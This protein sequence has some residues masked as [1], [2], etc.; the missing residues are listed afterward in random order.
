M[1][2]CVTTAAQLRALKR[3]Q[4]CLAGAVRARR[5]K[6]QYYAKSATWMAC[7]SAAVWFRGSAC[8]A[9]SAE[10][11]VLARLGADLW[12]PMIA[13]D[14]LQPLS[15]NYRRRRYTTIPRTEA[16]TMGC[17]TLART[18]VVYLF[19]YV[20]CLWSAAE[21]VHLSYIAWDEGMRKGWLAQS[22]TE[23]ANAAV[24]V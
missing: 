15:A 21:F 9:A 17:V 23:A 12:R 4:T 13:V 20:A 8:A 18:A 1:A 10:L 2:K 5:R 7:A 3:Q 22:L 19:P 24:A 14:T 6:V 16:I 11:L